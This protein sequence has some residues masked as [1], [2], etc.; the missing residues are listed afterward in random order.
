MKLFKMILVCF[1]IL[2]FSFTVLAE[3]A[4]V[5]GRQTITSSS[6]VG[7]WTCKSYSSPIFAG[8][9][10]AWEADNENLVAQFLGGTIIFQDD[11]DGTY[12]TLLTEQ[13]PF[14]VETTDTSIQCPYKIV[15]NILYIENAYFLW[16]NTRTVLSIYSI[17][18]VTQNKLIFK[19]IYSNG[20]EAK[21]VITERAVGN[22]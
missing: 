9:N 1:M 18:I 17:E 19:T 16:G 22:K 8:I 15:D 10:D 6:L 21:I 13:S 2:A 20:S 3:K 11:E 4:S 12:S 14:Y 5:V 7:E